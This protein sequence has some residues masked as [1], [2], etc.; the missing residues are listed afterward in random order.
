MH[1]CRYQADLPAI[2]YS[3]NLVTITSGAEANGIATNF[4]TVV[5]MSGE[6]YV[7]GAPIVFSVDG[8]ALFVLNRSSTIT[9]NTNN[10]GEATVFFVNQQ[11]ETVQ[12]RAVFSSDF[13]NDSST[14]GP[15]TVDNNL[16]LSA[17]VLTIDIVAGSGNPHI[18]NFLL[19][20]E[21]NRPVRGRRLDYSSSVP[22]TLTP[23][24]DTTNNDGV[25][26]LQVRSSS[27]GTVTVTARLQDA[28]TLVY[29]HIRVTFLEL[30]TTQRLLAQVIN[31][32]AS[33]NGISQNVIRY[34]A[35]DQNNLALGNVRIV[36]NASGNAVLSI[37][38]GDTDPE[39]YLTLTLTNGDV[40][41][42]R[43]IATLASGSG[44]PNSTTV[45]F[46]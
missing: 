42:V 14:F 39:G 37:P 35:L 30:I 4:F 46:V 41:S 16:S 25:T 32:I 5:L 31:G 6:D 29:I 20:D 3:L 40:Q 13:V 43:V 27:P 28:P 18:I 45:E 36:F 23:T 24:S 38:Y 19:T 8:S 7:D 26:V 33:A 1:S 11:V 21:L 22:V 9:V 34:R 17:E 10:Q 12:V 2:D 15:P 44:T